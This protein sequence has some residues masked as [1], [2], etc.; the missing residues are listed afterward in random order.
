MPTG[1][2]GVRFT[3]RPSTWSSEDHEL[4]RIVSPRLGNA[5]QVDAGRHGRRAVETLLVPAGA[6]LWIQGVKMQETGM[7]RRFET[8]PVSPGQEY[9]YTLKAEV[10]R[11]GEVFAETREVKLRAGAKVNVDFGDVS[12]W[13]RVPTG[14]PAQVS[15]R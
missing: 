6:E 9:T 2:A 13:A 5:Y 15:R 4:A 10:T 14:R 12:R 8:P 1:G 3:A 7:N 11:N